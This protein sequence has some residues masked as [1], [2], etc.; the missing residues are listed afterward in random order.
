MNIFILNSGRCGSKT[1]SIACKHITNYSSAHESRSRL[2]GIERLNYPKNHIESDCR[3]VYFL[4]RLDRLYG[5]D[6]FYVHL[7]RNIPD[8]IKSWEKRLINKGIIYAHTVCVLM[9]YEFAKTHNNAETF[10]IDYMD[11][12]DENIKMFLKD[13]PNQMNFSLENAKADF[14]IFWDR[15]GAQ[16]DKEKALKEWDIKHNASKN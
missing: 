3:L 14:R 15:I 13:K 4:G 10:I 7:K 2:L 5:K 9:N 6:A 8:C 16:G 1:F 11:T 12:V